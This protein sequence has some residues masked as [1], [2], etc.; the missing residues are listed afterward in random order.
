MGI[1]LSIERKISTGCTAYLIIYDSDYGP[2]RSGKGLEKP[3]AAMISVTFAAEGWNK[4]FKSV[5]SALYAF[6]SIGPQNMYVAG[7]LKNGFHKWYDS[8]TIPAKTP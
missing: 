1:K 4:P 6:M 3:T 8:H 7:M 2:H 5:S